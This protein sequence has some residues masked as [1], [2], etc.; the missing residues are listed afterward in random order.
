MSDEELAILSGAPTP[1]EIAERARV[2]RERHL[3]R[4]RGES[5]PPDD[6]DARLD[7]ERAKVQRY[8]DRQKQGM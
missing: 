8:R 4:M 6:L 7:R 3:A 5:L 2:V 1:A